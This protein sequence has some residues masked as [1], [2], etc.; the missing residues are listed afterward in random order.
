MNVNFNG[1]IIILG[2]GA[3]ARCLCDVLTRH[4]SCL[5]GKLLVLEPGNAN[6]EQVEMLC[7][8]GFRYQ[9]I[10]EL[11]KSNYKDVLR[12]YCV[13][14][15]LLVNLTCSVDSIALME[16]VHEHGMMYVDSSFEIWD[17]D[18]ED[19]VEDM[20]HHT[21]YA[22]HSRA[23]KVVSNWGNESPTAIS[24]HGANPGLVN[25]LTKAALVELA[26]ELN[27]SFI[28]PETSQGW[29]NLARQIGVKVI[30]ITERDTQVSRS[31]K[32][33]N[34]FRNTWSPLAFMDEASSPAEI[35]WGTHEAEMPEKSYLHEEGSGC[36]LYFHKTGG[37]VFI[38]SWLPKGGSIHGYMMPH[39]EC[40]TMSDYFTLYDNETV[41]YRPTI[42]FVYLP[43]PDAFVSIHEYIM[44]DWTA[45]QNLK[46]LNEE[47]SSGEDELGVLLLGHAKNAF[48]FG[49]CVDI[50]Y[51]RKIAIGHNAT[52]VQVVG[53]VIAAIIWC[54]QNPNSGYCE[55]E[56]LPFREILSIAEPYIGPLI[57]KVSDWTPSESQ[58]NSPS[59]EQL[60]QF[61]N[62]IVGR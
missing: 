7:A 19:F 5:P 32:P 40:V 62:F 52:T 12:D 38:K 10:D 54:L 49:S 20:Q 59:E 24:N 42:K 18:Q 11:N 14:G 55:T 36:S 3:I 16:F 13:Q 45:H 29:A 28:E 58:K 53:G 21:L 60:W 15:D 56:D 30:H 31:S 44:S 23:R 39:S 41:I 34:E 27:L 22:L 26:N 43:A 51:A 25:H 9:I 48:W 33:L 37:E 4:V 8:Q 61:H 1:R 17:E 6:S 57:Q 50:E 35:G 2:Y 47:I 46:L